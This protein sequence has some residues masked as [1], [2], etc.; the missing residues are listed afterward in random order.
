MFLFEENK[1][2]KPAENEQF[3][4]VY[5]ESNGVYGGGA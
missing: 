1:K 5:E 3:R 4:L 2:I